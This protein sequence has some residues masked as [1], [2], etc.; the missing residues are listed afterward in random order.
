MSTRRRPVI[1]RETLEAMTHM[2][3]AAIASALG[4]HKHTIKTYLEE[5]GL[6]ALD[7]IKR[8]PREYLQEACD[9]LGAVNAVAEYFK[10]NRATVRRWL[11]ELDCVLVRPVTQP[12]SR[13]ALLEDY[14]ML[15]VMGLCGNAVWVIE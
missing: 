12:P 6:A 3:A 5:Y 4:Y 9:V 13:D 8:P 15:G 7:K 11:V 1:V 2:S 10:V 14:T